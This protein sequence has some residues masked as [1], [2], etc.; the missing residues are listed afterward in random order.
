MMDFL[1]DAFIWVL[2]HLLYGGFLLGTIVF[3]VWMF[4]YALGGYKKSSRIPW[5]WG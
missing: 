1:Y 4:W 3:I 5:W 2:A